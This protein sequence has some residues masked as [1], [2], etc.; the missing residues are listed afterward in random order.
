MI[1]GTDT[2]IPTQHLFFSVLLQ[3]LLNDFYKNKK[4][5]KNLYKQ[6]KGNILEK[7]EIPSFDIYPCFSMVTKNVP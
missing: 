2:G 7:H 5:K 3:K 4:D 1:Y 6:E